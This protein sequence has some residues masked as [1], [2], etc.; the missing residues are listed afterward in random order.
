[1]SKYSTLE[2]IK[3]EV[4]EAIELIDKL[5]YHEV[6]EHRIDICLNKRVKRILGQCT[7]LQANTYQLSFNFQ[8]MLIGSD[9]SCR[10]TIYHEVI[11]T[12]N[13]GMRHTGAWLECAKAV[14]L[15]TGLHIARNTYDSDYIAWLKK[16]QYRYVIICNNCN[17]TVCQRIRKTAKLKRLQQYPENFVCPKCNIQGLLTVH[18]IKEGKESCQQRAV[19]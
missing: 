7:K 17:S 18:D 1:M 5:G 3:I 11:H 8:Y 12:I 19:L 2:A 9:L 13:G 14:N 4:S 16:T 10:Q 6:K 15:K